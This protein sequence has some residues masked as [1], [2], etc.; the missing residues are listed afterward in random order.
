VATVGVAALVAAAPGYAW[1]TA[2]ASLIDTNGNTAGEVRVLV[3]GGKM[4][5]TARVQVPG[6]FTGFHGFHI[7]ATGVCDPKAAN[8]PF[9]TA[10]GHLSEAGTTHRSHWGDLPALLV[11]RDGTASM[12]VRTDRVDLAKLFDADGAAVVMH[13]GPDNFANIPTRYAPN[14][15][16]TA[17]LGTGDAGGRLACGVL[18]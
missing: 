6:E 3:S 10:G 17:T 14:G 15:P 7:H 4:Q 8:G 12:T 11:N 13:V 1:H 2:S 16:D 5:V 9:S 18:R